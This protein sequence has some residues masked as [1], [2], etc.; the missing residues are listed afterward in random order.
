MVC[1]F[2]NNCNIYSTQ[3]IFTS[4]ITFILT[5]PYMLERG[6]INIPF[7]GNENQGRQKTELKHRIQ[8]LGY[9]THA[10]LSFSYKRR[11]LGQ[12]Y[13][14][15]VML[16][17]NMGFPGG[18]LVRNLLANA[19]D[20]SEA[21][22][23]PRSGKPPGVGHGKLL[24]YSCLENSMDRGTWWVTVH[25]VTKSQTRLITTT[26]KCQCRVTQFLFFFFF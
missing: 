19:G 18:T 6:K 10:S 11:D 3:S 2:K 13:C 24:Q 22:W 7:I 16:N 17:V 25:G 1:G 8:S 15:F 26:N 4:F 23:T 12:K 20:S 14:F 21:G 5:K 9:N